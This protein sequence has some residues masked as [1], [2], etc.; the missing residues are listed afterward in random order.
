MRKA[1]TNTP[2]SSTATAISV[3]RVSRRMRAISAASRTGSRGGRFGRA[4]RTGW[5][6]GRSVSLFGVAGCS[7]S[8]HSL[9]HFATQ[10]DFRSTARRDRITA[11]F[12]RTRGIDVTRVLR[13][14]RRF[15]AARPG[16][17][18]VAVSGGA[19]SV[20]LLRA[21]HAAHPGP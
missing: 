14:V 12:Y 17:G 2:M 4:G 7:D 19:D 11:P 3:A 9:R 5:A 20:A 18:V 6:T 16:P 15:A 10:A 8:T 21:L 1:A 13:E